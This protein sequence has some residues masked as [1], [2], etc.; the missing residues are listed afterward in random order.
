M[1]KKE[2][3]TLRELIDA[4]VASAVTDVSGSK[5]VDLDALSKALDKVD[6]IGNV[7]VAVLPDGPPDPGKVG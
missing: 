7:R 1:A 6:L 3:K 4:A 5:V 2:L